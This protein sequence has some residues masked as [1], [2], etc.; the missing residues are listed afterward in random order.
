MIDIIVPVFNEGANILKLFA[1]VGQAIK[2][3]KRVTVIYD[4]DEDNTVPVAREHMGEYGYEIR[5][6]RNLI[7]RGA[8]NAIKT[9]FQV[10]TED[11]V[12][13]I[14]ADLS[15]SLEIADKMA[16][17]LDNGYDLV[18]GSRYMSGGKQ[19][20]GPLLKGLFSR[21]AGVSLHILTRIPTRDVTNSF[22][23]YSRRVLERFTVES[24]GGFELG[25]EL[26]V[27][28]YVHGMRVTEIPSQWYDRAEGESNFKMWK[29]LPKYLRWYFYCIGKTWFGRNKKA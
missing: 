23:M 24:T 18:C 25:I 9:G 14:M 20:G 12:L 7:A 3:S 17:L 8:L 26:T 19:H 16:E 27:K 21:C 10:S 11:K 13:V 28:A 6:Q 5:L 2:S 1:K 15:D 22:K 29:W 4:Y